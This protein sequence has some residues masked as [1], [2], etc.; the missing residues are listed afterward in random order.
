MKEEDR[1]VCPTSSDRQECLSHAWPPRSS[2][3]RRSEALPRRLPWIVTLI[4][5]LAASPLRGGLAPEN[6]AV[7]VEPTQWTSLTLANHYVDMRRIPSANVVRVEGRGQTVALFRNTL[8]KPA[9]E[10]LLA[11]GL[12]KQIRCIA[13]SDAFPTKVNLAEDLKTIENRPKII[14]GEGSINGLTYLYQM[15]AHTN[16]QYV[17]MKSNLLY[18]GPNPGFVPGEPGESASSY[19]KRVKKQ[20]VDIETATAHTEAWGF[21]DE[22]YLPS[23]VLGA[24]GGDGFPVHTWIDALQRAT[25]AD[26]TAPDGTIYLMEG[27]DIRSKTREWAYHPVKHALEKRGIQVQIESG[28]LPDKKRDVAGAVLGRATLDWPGSGSR[29]LPGAIVE[30]L[31]SFGGLIRRPGG[32]QTSLIH[33][34]EAGAAGSSGTVTEPYAIQAKFPSPFIHVHYADGLRLAE[35]FYRSI[36]AP[37]QLLIIGDPLCAPWVKTVKVAI[38]GLV[39]NQLIDQP[40]TVSFSAT[41]SEAVAYAE[42]FMDGRY[43][44]TSGPGTA[45]PIDPSGPEGERELVMQPVMPNRTTALN[46]VQMPFRFKGAASDQLEVPAT[47]FYGDPIVVRIPEES[48]QLSVSHFGT[49]IGIGSGNAVTVSSYAVG[50]G[51]VRLHITATLTGGRDLH[52]TKTVNVALPKPLIPLVKE[53]SGL[54]PGIRLKPGAREAQVLSSING[55]IMKDQGGLKPNEAAVFE[56]FLEVPEAGLYRFQVVGNGVELLIN[57]VSVLPD[58][59]KRSNSFPLSFHQ[60]IYP[61]RLTV[62][63]PARASVHVSFGKDRMAPLDATWLRYAL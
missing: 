8:L 6:I 35:A 55:E 42:W 41:G 9:F 54:T 61:I 17:S 56:G 47:V 53:P 37:Y 12:Q 16:V 33:F 44:G 62:H 5:L 21:V 27:G 39:A 59:S 4:L 43:L 58:P 60:G 40:F 11:R 34:I 36:H 32:G 24:T 2:W 10:E 30:N 14:T 38:S 31:T 22:P 57:E 45:F 51:P 26:G 7:F 49:L 28:A 46:R 18:A 23:I 19:L 29:I 52:W 3:F 13:W 48:A 63:T 1:S 25:D 20:G 50:M 15:V